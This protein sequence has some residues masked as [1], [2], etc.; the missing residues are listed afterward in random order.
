MQSYREESSSIVVSAARH[1][2]L[3]KYH[4]RYEESMNP[5]EAFRG[6]VRRIFLMD[7]KAR[8]NLTFRISVM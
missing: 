2:D 4:A 5:F 8:D 3:N 1:D 6:R 7:S